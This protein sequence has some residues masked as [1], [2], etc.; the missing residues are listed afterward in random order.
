MLRVCPGLGDKPVSIV[1]GDHHKVPAFDVGGLV[2]KVM[3]VLSF[4]YQKEF[5]KSMVVLFYISRRPVE[6][7]FGIRIQE[8]LFL[9]D[10]ERILILHCLLLL[11]DS[12]ISLFRLFVNR[13]KKRKSKK[14]R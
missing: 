12:N 6:R 8:I 9:M 1:W 11:T 3:Y 13:L 10:A 14:E 5:V 2:V 4:G 7:G